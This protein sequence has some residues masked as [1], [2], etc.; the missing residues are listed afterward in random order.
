MAD[1][2]GVRV[3]GLRGVVRALQQMGAEVEDLKAAFGRIADEGARRAAGHAPKRSG[4]LAADVRGNR[5]KSK[6]VVTAGRSSV[7][8]AGPIQYGWPARNIR[9]NP[10]MTKASDEMEPRA[11]QMLEDEIN[12]QIQRRGLR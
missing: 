9:A 11:V 7:P 3:D 4:R 12:Q 8:Y 6:A 2:V 5:A 10:F 1:R